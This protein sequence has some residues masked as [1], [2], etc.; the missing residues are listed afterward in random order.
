MCYQI[1]TCSFRMTP[2]EAAKWGRSPL[3]H[4]YSLLRSQ[5]SRRLLR[6]RLLTDIYLS[7]LC[8]SLLKEVSSGTPGDLHCVILTFGVRIVGTLLIRIAT[9]LVVP[10][11]TQQRSSF[12]LSSA[13]R[14]MG[15]NKASRMSP[16]FFRV[17]V[18]S[19]YLLCSGSFRFKSY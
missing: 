7:L 8:R 11:Q 4:L 15:K 9:D 2:W 17:G 1:L 12:R 10:R 19:S 6:V 13:P 5:Y 18:T 14:T 16:F 3:E